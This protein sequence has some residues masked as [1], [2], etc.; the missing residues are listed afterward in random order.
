PDRAE[1]AAAPACAPA[2]RPE[3]PLRHPP[4]PV[5][6]PWHLQCRTVR[7]TFTAPGAGKSIFANVGG[8][9]QG[10]GA[11]ADAFGRATVFDGSCCA[12]SCASHCAAAVPMPA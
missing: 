5:L 9:D 1:S 4:Q 10:A 8:V 11:G 6:A 7:A 3:P 12:A 2:A